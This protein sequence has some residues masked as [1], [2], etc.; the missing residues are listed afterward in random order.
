MCNES[1][2]QTLCD[3][4][5]ETDDRLWELYSYDGFDAVTV[6]RWTA[7]ELIEA[8]MDHPRVPA[9]ETVEAFALK[10]MAFRTIAEGREPAEQIFSLA[11]ENALEWLELFKKGDRNE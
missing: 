10:M 2:L 5:D 9:E 4:L 11:A 7:G 8:I 6:A 1:A 3:Y